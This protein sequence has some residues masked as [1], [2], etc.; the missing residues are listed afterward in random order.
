MKSL[1]EYTLTER[2]HEGAGAD[3]Y[4]GYRSSD[5]A[6]V[7]VK[8][9]RSE[10][11]SSRDVAKLRH[12]HA[13]TKELEGPNIP[14]TYGLEKLGGR[15]ALIMENLGGQP[16][17]DVLRAGRLPL[18]TFLRI[19]VSLANTLEWIHRH[20]I[21]HKDIKPANI[22]IEGDGDRVKLIDFG[23]ATRL[24]QETQRVRSPD[25]LEGTLAYMSPEQTGRM[26][27]F[28]DH[29]TDFYSLGVT[30]YEMAT[31]SLPFQ[32][33]D[34]M[35]LVHSHIARRPAPPHEIAPD[36][37]ES[38][39]NII[40]K[41]LSK[42]AED[43]YQ[44]A[45]GLKADLQA[46]LDQWEATGKIEPFP[47]GRSDMSDELRVPQKLYGRE[48]ES[49]TL[50]AAWSRVTRGA[51]ELLL[52]SGYSGVGKSA[53]VNEIHKAIAHEGGHFV[54]GKFEELSRSIPYAAVARALRELL[55]Q[56]LDE[57]REARE[58]W[59]REI[60]RAVGTSGKVLTDLLPELAL[61]IGPQESVQEL[62]PTEAQN[63][64]ALVFQSF[65]RALATAEHPLALFLDDLQWADPA[66]LKLLE[67]SLSDPASKHLFIVGAY[68]DN[69]V[70]AAHPLALAI[71]AI[72]K[73]RAA[74]SEIKL[75][76][77]NLSTVAQITADALGCDEVRASELADFLF[78]KTAGNPF[79][80][81][82]LLLGLHEAKLLT[83]DRRAGAWM[84]SIES[85]HRA[86]ITDNVVDFIA[87]KVRRLPP[88]AQRA[89]ELA[90]CI[91]HQFDL[92][93]LRATGEAP[94]HETAKALW[95]ALRE[96]LLLPLD[97]E[98]RLLDTGDNDNATAAD[99]FN[100]R[101]K[102]LHDRVQQAA[103]SLMEHGRRQEVHLR[104]GRLIWR[105]GERDLPEDKLF[106]AAN[107]LN[108]GVAL[109]T[110]RDERVAVAHLNLVAGRKAKA[111]TAYSAAA[112]YLKA[113]MALLGEAGFD[114]EYDLWFGLCTERA[115]CEYL[116]GSFEQAAVLFGA[117]LTRVRSDI[118]RAHV[119]HLRM[120]LDCTLGKFA[121]ALR[122]GLAGL[123]L[124]G[125]TLPETEEDV[126]AAL[127]AELAEVRIN[128]RDRPIEELAGTPLMTD[129]A[130]RAA[131]KLLT[132]L[133]SPAFII[134][135]DLYSLVV[136]KQVNLSL[137]H[138]HS[139]L[140]AYGY[141]NY[142][143][144]LAAVLN[145]FADAFAFGQLA[146][147]LNE[148][149]GNVDLSC[150]LNF[151]VGEYIHFFKPL[152]A[153]LDYFARA[154]RDGMESGDFP[155]L[156]YVSRQ[157]LMTRLALGHDLD[158]VQKEVARSLTLMERTKDTLSSAAIQV[159]KQMVANLEGRTRSRASLSDDT[160]DENAFVRSMEEAGLPFV[161][162]W[163]YTVK[164]ELSFLHGDFESALAMATFAAENSSTSMGLYHTTELPFYTCLTL[165]ALY[166]KRSATEQEQI[167]ASV[168][169]HRARLER[170]AE[171][172]PENYKHKHLLVLAELAR[173]AGSDEA[174]ELYDQAIA[175]AEASGFLQDE[176]IAS[177][178]CAQYHA[179]RDRPKVA[180]VYMTDAYHA[181]L[182]WGARAK[183]EDIALKSYHLL[184]HVTAVPSS[185]S[186]RTLAT[187]PS[188]ASTTT[189]RASPEVLDM[190]AILR[191]AQTIA[192]EIIL[193][194]VLDRV[195]R[196]VI[197]NAG[198]QRGLLLL[199]RDGRLMVEASISVDPDQVEV[200]LS[201]PLLGYADIPLRVI[202]Y[203]QRTWEPVIMADATSDARFG[204]DPYIA[205]KRPKSVLCLALSH[206]GRLTGILYLENNALDDAFTPGRIE[207][208]G[209]LSS[210]AA[211]AVENA[212]L[213]ARVS[214]VTAE[215]KR[216]NEVLETEV[217]NRTVE[218][219]AANE[220]LA[221]E[222]AERRRSDEAR[223]ALQE[224]IIRAQRERLAELS[225]P[226]IPITS[227]IMVMPLIGT[228][229]A[230]RAREVLAAA[231][232]GARANM[233]EVVILDITGIKIVDMGVASTLISTAGTLRLL[234]VQAVITGV[235]PEVAQTLVG[236]NVDLGAFVT[237]GTLESGIAYALSRSKRARSGAP[238]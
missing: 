41:L 21:I 102:F 226:M 162:C 37:P 236:L 93:T 229:D 165:L 209:M 53:L 228:M 238:R 69:E 114:E 140:S 108:L 230:A 177:E 123:A 81:S 154:Y 119:Y 30:L 72:R 80:I 107:H 210:H 131:L 27:R 135:R 175:A 174:A 222:F 132:S 127:S 49:A 63:R 186:P 68:R 55:R 43:R 196:I 73:T 76:P 128:L 34:P 64:F 225:T 172:S 121:D 213:Y 199:M 25:S 237:R 189:K 1:H 12:E 160:F 148:R 156:S 204:G 59:E 96:G 99:G 120:V 26:N 116:I 14:K 220:R 75:K 23:I 149:L 164:L 161:I 136:V 138:G 65:L 39:S 117:L 113:G 19:A 194:K 67:L 215:L 46:C 13:I 51:T 124:F 57:R 42:A 157:I 219:R 151:L 200:G 202:D 54:S 56:I 33:K 190:A 94:P 115:E 105:R 159:G 48:M 5:H 66:S 17:S 74:V 110:E 147:D 180:R 184:S 122:T 61:L 188:A 129:P 90:A 163:Y 88:A 111:A 176:A 125:I 29:R 152:R 218:L 95:E 198:A 155:Y 133:T 233:A 47:L 6:P 207:V 97:A 211:I 217:A 171:H 191:A 106:D 235:R 40:M 158:D 221:R 143:L 234:G 170:W 35:E 192:G 141:A 85:I 16:L 15:V 183:A 144:I 2:I 208:C 78:D 214:A 32:S 92:T 142:G 227:R 169:A 212:L 112:G 197:A 89:L 231:L 146:L 232:E 58:V 104:I 10:L 77:L 60:A 86:G 118:E 45:H 44:R 87:S 203:V 187:L 84:W 91:G 82:Q 98:Y 179:S 28:L 168:A 109:I 8:V 70:D 145:Q 126:R 205:S 101:Y 50:M 103:Y 178:L 38:V 182:G 100:V 18:Q 3:I 71:D 181:Y 83:F 224:E 52:V 24:F 4:V 134:H 137:K 193:E 11:P 31:G 201:L 167:L 195:M 9:L 150:K 206:Q 185:W 173:V 153:S 216:A 62:G 223:A 139:D 7:T 79:F 166:P 22:L 20:H 36:F 130:K